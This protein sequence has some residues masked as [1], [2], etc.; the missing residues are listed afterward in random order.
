MLLTDTNIQ[1]NRQFTD[2]R[3]WILIGFILAV[4][5]TGI[6]LQSRS[7]EKGENYISREAKIAAQAAGTTPCL[8]L[9][10]WLTQAKQA[11]NGQRVRDI[12]KAQKF[13][14]C[15][16]I[17]KRSEAS[18]LMSWY[19]AH[20]IMYVKFKDGRQ[21]T[22]PFWE[23]IILIEADSDEEAMSSA[24][25]R[26]KEDTGDSD[27]T[28]TWEGRPATWCFAGVRKLV[29]CEDADNK[30]GDGTEITYLEM[31]VD[32]EESLAR[33]VNGE[34]VIVRYN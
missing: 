28:F 34:P 18:N 1:P 10:L 31:E 29:E 27:G 12:V 9:K 14:G 16:N 20:T 15:R 19:A 7:R 25:A 32:G 5:V 6:F 17:E 2:I 3:K 21:T 11:G 13:L 4:A 33:L 24:I 26:A 22:Y 8:I 30:P 23:N